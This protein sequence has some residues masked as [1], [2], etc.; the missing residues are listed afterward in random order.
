MLLIGFYCPLSFANSDNKKYKESLLYSVATN[1]EVAVRRILSERSDIKEQL[2]PQCR[3]NQICKPIAYAVR[4]KSIEITSLLLDAGADI[5]STHG[6]SR[7]TPL[8]IALS[9]GHQEMVKLLLNRG[10]DL[11]KSNR[12]GVSPFCGLC[13]IGDVEL[14]K[15]FLQGGVN[16]DSRCNI[17]DYM[18]KKKVYVSNV[19]PLM[20]ASKK[21]FVDVVKLLIKN[22]ANTDLK[23]SLGRSAMDYSIQNAHSKIT[24]LL[25]SQ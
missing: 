8:I 25:I 10:A 13:A 2:D 17:P 12:F 11:N 7:D 18:D 4:N 23:D 5:N 24:D 14:I 21:G 6:F 22:G 20:M 9:I 16:V 19:T 15:L 3:S 1:D